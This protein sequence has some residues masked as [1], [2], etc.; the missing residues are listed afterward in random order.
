M[1]SYGR[2]EHNVGT[3]KLVT[4]GFDNIPQ[5]WILCNAWC[6]RMVRNKQYGSWYG[7][8]Q[9]LDRPGLKS[10]ATSQLCSVYLFKCALVVYYMCTTSVSLSKMCTGMV[11]LQMCTS[12]SL[13]K[14]AQVWHWYL[15]KC[16]LVVAWSLVRIMVWYLNK[17][18]F[19]NV[20]CARSLSKCALVVGWSLRPGQPLW[21][22]MC[23]SCILHVY[24]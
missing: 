24:Y 3:A 7:S 16:A 9:L 5:L 23:T 11:P 21:L 19:T 10:F 13:S 8:D 15:P 22:Q 1:K 4:P 2:G 12:C 6:Y 18:N 14:C 20:W 17:C